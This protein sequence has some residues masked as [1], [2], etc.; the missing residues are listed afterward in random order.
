MVL[1]A[2]AT[3]IIIPA[4]ARITRR[5]LAG[6]VRQIPTQVRSRMLTSLA[7]CRSLQLTI[8][9]LLT[10]RCRG[11]IPT[12]RHLPT[13]RRL[14]ATHLAKALAPALAV[15]LAVAGL[16]AHPMATQAEAMAHL[17]VP[18]VAHP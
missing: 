8:P 16:A 4:S 17:E 3:P 12:S 1:P 14:P 6:L 10:P 5:A 18:L 9:L 13:N 15:A 7:L 11:L 2:S